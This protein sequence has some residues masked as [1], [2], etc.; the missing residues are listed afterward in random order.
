MKDQQER[1]KGKQHLDGSVRGSSVWRPGRGSYTGQVSDRHTAPLSVPSPDYDQP[2]LHPV[3]V[4][5]D[6]L[7]HHLVL[8]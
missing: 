2:R 4:L 1:R 3:L 8:M 7:Y 6:Q 5:R